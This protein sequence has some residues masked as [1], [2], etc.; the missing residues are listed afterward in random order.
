VLSGSQT[1]LW[2]PA[3]CYLAQGVA[4]LR[5][6]VPRAKEYAHTEGQLLSR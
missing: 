4:E 2:D 5:Q 6:Q 1:L 3:G